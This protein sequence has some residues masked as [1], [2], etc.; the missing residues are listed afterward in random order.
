MSKT[1]KPKTLL[2]GWDAADWNVITPLINKGVMPT[3]AN[4]I[5]K[6]SH[7][8]IA[9]LNPPLSPL[10]WTSIATGKRAYDH[11]I[12]GFTELGPD[13]KTVRAIRGSSRTAK[14]FWEIFSE[15]NIKTNVIGWW[16]SHPAEAV[17]GHMVSNFYGLCNISYGEE[18]P[19]MSRT[20]YPNKV[21]EVL[22]ELR[23]HPG[24][25][26]PE[27]LKPFFPDAENLLS[28]NDEVLRS[29]MKILAHCSSI[30]NATTW[31]M[32]NTEWDCT[33]VYYDA[34][35]HFSHLAMKYHPPKIDGIS[36][37]DFKNYHYI[38][39]AAYRFHDMMLD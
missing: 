33:A 22:K 26:T 30:H 18:W 11:G 37:R 32:E 23:L 27:I 34:L 7:G 10:L 9:T 13:Q 8:K 31:L 14:T 38:V 35:D 24:E 3:L 29:V 4:L 25:L 15:N 21:E 17:N 36:S 39:E 28:N 1:K 6:G 5:S 12:T 19:M 2:I 16:P 20:V